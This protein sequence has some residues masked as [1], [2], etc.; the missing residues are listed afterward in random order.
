MKR[1]PEE[2]LL[3]CCARTNADSETTARIRALLNADINWTL[4][5]GLALRHGMLPLV[6]RQLKEIEPDIIAQARAESLMR[7]F[8]AIAGRDLW[9]TNELLQILQTFRD[10]A[11]EAVP[12][13]GPVLA[14]VLV[15]LPAMRC[16]TWS[17]STRLAL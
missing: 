9:L 16:K 15:R 2:E 11:I 3:I 6:Y 7:G 10:Q 8:F 4:F 5:M 13:K 12:L 1:K 17:Q 14:L